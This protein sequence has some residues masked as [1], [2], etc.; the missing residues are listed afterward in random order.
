MRID[1]I[2]LVRFTTR[3][4]RATR[5]DIKIVLYDGKICKLYDDQ[6]LPYFYT[7]LQNPQIVLSDTVNIVIVRPGSVQVHTLIPVLD[8]MDCKLDVR[9]YV[10]IVS[11]ASSGCPGFQTVPIQTGLEK[12]RVS[13]IE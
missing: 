5:T 8:R 4:C 9:A 1:V 11:P 7:W 3:V 2:R 6:V 10:A 13:H 12:R